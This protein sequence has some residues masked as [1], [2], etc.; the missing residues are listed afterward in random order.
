MTTLIR[1][2]KKGF[3]NSRSGLAIQVRLSFVIFFHSLDALFVCGD[4][5]LVFEEMR[6]LLLQKNLDHGGGFDKVGL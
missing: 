1:V 5:C 6:V 2:F 3:D 4:E